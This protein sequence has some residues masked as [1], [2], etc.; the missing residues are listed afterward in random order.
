MT[1]RVIHEYIVARAKVHGLTM[2]FTIKDEWGTALSDRDYKRGVIEI[3]PD[4]DGATT[5][6]DYQGENCER[7]RHSYAIRAMRSAK[8]RGQA[9]NL[10]LDMITDFKDAMQSTNDNLEQPYVLKGQ[11]RWE[12]VK[13]STVDDGEVEADFNVVQGTFK[14]TLKEY[15]DP[16][17]RPNRSYI[18]GEGGQVIPIA[19]TGG[20]DDLGTFEPAKSAILVIN[21][22]RYRIA[23]DP[24]DS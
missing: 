1:E 24:E 22:V 13:I 11:M 16:G 20:V 4:P 21:G 10:V 3:E 14:M 23:L 7:V 15:L 18:I 19:A 2:G 17:D 8:S 12:P 6:E 9:R 5:L